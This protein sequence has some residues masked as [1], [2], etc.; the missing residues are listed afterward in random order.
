MIKGA[1]TVEPIHDLEQIREMKDDLLHKLY[2]DYFLFV[3]I[4]SGLRIC[5]ILPLRVLDVASA[6]HL[7]FK[8]QKTGKIRKVRRLPCSRRLPNTQG[9]RCVALFVALTPRQ[10][11]DQSGD[12][13]EDHQ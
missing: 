2:R 11:P 4:N 12:G 13:L 7:R 9:T 3:G 10:Q 6:T 5:D 1:N 8:E